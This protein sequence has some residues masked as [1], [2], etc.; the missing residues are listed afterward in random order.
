MPTDYESAVGDTPSGELEVFGY[1]LRGDAM[2]WAME[3]TA[4]AMRARLEVTV[5]G[6]PGGVS[7]WW[8]LVYLDHH[9]PQSQAEMARIVGVDGKVL[10]HRLRQMDEERL[11]ALTAQEHDRRGVMVA[12]TDKGAAV[13]EGHRAR[14]AAEVDRLTAGA[15]PW[16]L[17][18]FRR[19]MRVIHDNLRQP[20]SGS[21]NCGSGVAPAAR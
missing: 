15:E 9:G 10:A 17:D 16:D 8:V 11:I 13:R 19:V 20:R 2:V 21:A 18:A 1:Q 5:R 3:R 7:A 14:A 12:L 4:H 6:V